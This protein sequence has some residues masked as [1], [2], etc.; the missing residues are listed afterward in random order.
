MLVLV[1]IIDKD[2]LCCFPC[3]IIAE[4]YSQFSFYIAVNN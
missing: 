1:E 4:I 2:S 3:W